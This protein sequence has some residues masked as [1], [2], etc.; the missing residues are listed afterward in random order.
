MATQTRNAVNLVGS[1]TTRLVHGKRKEQPGKGLAISI[2]C[3]FS[4][5]TVALNNAT[6][7]HPIQRIRGDQLLPPAQYNNN[8]QYVWAD[9]STSTVDGIHS[10]TPVALSAD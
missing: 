7:N 2:A 10:S 3:F 9:F 6:T 4:A 1:S 8:A 5:S